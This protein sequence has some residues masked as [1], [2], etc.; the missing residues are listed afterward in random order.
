M[1]GT[2]VC[3]WVG[4]RFVYGRDQGLCMGRTKV[5]GTKVCVFGLF[6]T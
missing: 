5:G 2:K 6:S 4:P 3:V 1:G